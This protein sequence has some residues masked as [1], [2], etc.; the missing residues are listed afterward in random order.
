MPALLSYRGRG[1]REDKRG[2][3]WKNIFK[4]SSKRSGVEVKMLG[5][6]PM[7]EYSSAPRLE[8]LSATLFDVSDGAPQ[9]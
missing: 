8:I 4:F 7:N 9:C 2:D 3:A 6:L 1:C 5:R